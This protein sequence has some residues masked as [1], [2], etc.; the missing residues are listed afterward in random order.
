[1]QK[2][3]CGDFNQNEIAV[4]LDAQRFDAPDGRVA[5]RRGRAEGAEVVRPD[6]RARCAVHALVI[7]G[8]ADPRRA[9]GGE[10]RAH[11]TVEHIVPIGARLGG[12]TGV[13]VAR[14]RT[15]PSDIDIV[16][17]TRVG[18][19]YPAAGA[20]PRLGV[21]VRDLSAGVYAGISATGADDIDRRCGHWA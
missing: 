14:Y 15:G 7:E 18:A 11:G 10:R 1:M 21:E 19:Q 20:A 13:K 12:V 6:K 5:L 4:A 3:V 2:R 17:Q 8:M 9:P 16:R